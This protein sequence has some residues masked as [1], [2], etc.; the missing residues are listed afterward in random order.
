MYLTFNDDFF[1]RLSLKMLAVLNE[2]SN[3]IQGKYILG[4]VKLKKGCEVNLK[5][6]TEVNLP[7][8]GFISF[9][10]EFCFIFG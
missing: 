8:S 2:R 1:F 7:I 4:T 6:M 5:G 3:G 10:K 9:F